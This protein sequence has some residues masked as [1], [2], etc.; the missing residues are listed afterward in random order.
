MRIL[1]VEDD[2]VLGS[3]VRD[4]IAADGHSV[5]WATRLD[6][7]RD[8]TAVAVC[9]TSCCRTGAACI[10]CARCAGGAT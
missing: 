4:Q 7:A 6:A 10:S 1:L 8:A 5:D 2:D 3:A 9:L